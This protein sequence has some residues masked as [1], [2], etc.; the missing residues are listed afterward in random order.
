MSDIL[1]EKSGLTACITINRPEQRNGITGPMLTQLADAL[2]RAETDPEV[3][4]VVLTGAG[5]M[6]CSGIDF[7]GTAQDAAH[8]EGALALDFDLQ[9]FPPAWLH[10]METPSIC[11][12]NGGAAGFGMDLAL[13]CDIRIAAENARMASGYV[14]TGVGP[15][16]SAGTWLLPRIV[17]RSVAAEILLTGRKL[18]AETLL[19]LGLVSQ[20][21]PADRLTEQAQSLA[22]EIAANAPLSVRATKRMLRFAENEPFEAH[23]QRC[24]TTTLHLLRTEDCQEG[25]QAFM[26]RRTPSF[27]GR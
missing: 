20:L 1:Y 7:G 26:E 13:G 27:Q 6:F 16:E 10:R 3:R 19:R 15:P 4:A 25:I 5:S 23:S 14:T 2:E 21:V 12:L 22:D 11:A 18:D 17:G 8:A 24:F 9:H